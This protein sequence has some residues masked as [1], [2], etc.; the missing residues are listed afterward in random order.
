[1]GVIKKVILEPSLEGDE[2][3]I[4]MKLTTTTTPFFFFTSNKIRTK[5]EAQSSRGPCG[6]QMC[7][8]LSLGEAGQ[9]SG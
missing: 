7:G 4:S 8:L 5:S 1:M 2:G 6:L 3:I 9:D